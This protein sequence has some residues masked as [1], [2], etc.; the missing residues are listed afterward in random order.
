MKRTN[1]PLSVLL[2]DLVIESAAAR[3]S[4]ESREDGNGDSYYS[5]RVVIKYSDKSTESLGGLRQYE[6]R[7][8]YGPD[9][10]FG[11]VKGMLEKH[12]GTDRKLTLD[13]FI[14]E[15]Y[16][17]KVKVKSRDWSVGGQKGYKN[18]PVEFVE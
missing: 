5:W 17:K 7:I 3:K 18:I 6:D 14:K 16:G 13:E 12:L 2:T 15:L 10:A 1:C 4:N 11:E 8:W 9:S